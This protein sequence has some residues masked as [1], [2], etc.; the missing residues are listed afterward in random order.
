MQELQD[1][2]DWRFPPEGFLATGRITGEPV[3]CLTADV[4]ILWR[5]GYEPDEKDHHDM[6]ALAR[7]FAIEL[8]APYRDAT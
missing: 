5:L 3:P 1:G 7:H 8:P 2:T 6:H 4:Q